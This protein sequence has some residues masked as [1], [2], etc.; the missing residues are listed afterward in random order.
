M[1]GGHEASIVMLKPIQEFVCMRIH[2]IYSSRHLSGVSVVIFKEK[3]V[4][5]ARQAKPPR[6]GE[7]NSPDSI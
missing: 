7:W 4:L 5:L 1:V 3:R 2:R 6:Q